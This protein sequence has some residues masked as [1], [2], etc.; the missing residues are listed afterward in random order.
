[1]RLF[2]KIISGPGETRKKREE[3]KGKRTK[4]KGLGNVLDETETQVGVPGVGEVPEPGRRTQ[5]LR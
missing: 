4:C 2:T 1:M 5:E 3:A